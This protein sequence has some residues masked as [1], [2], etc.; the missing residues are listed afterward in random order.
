[1]ILISYAQVDDA[2]AR[3]LRPAVVHVD[4][5]NKITALGDD[6]AE[7]APGT[8]TVRPPHAVARV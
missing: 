5:A 4:A 7:P 1:V 8:D 6:T 2:E 3:A